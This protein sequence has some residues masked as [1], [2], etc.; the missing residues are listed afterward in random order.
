MLRGT[1]DADDG[2]F[3]L[4]PGQV[5]VV[6]DLALLDDRQRFVGNQFEA[7]LSLGGGR[8]EAPAEA[9]ITPDTSPRLGEAPPRPSDLAPLPCFAACWFLGWRAGG[10]TAD[11]DAFGGRGAA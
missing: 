6:R 7:I 8:V 9:R 10:G 4:T 3:W 5:Q 1:F 11:A 2:A